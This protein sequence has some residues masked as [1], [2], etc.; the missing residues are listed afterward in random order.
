MK[1]PCIFVL[2]VRLKKKNNTKMSLKNL[3][4]TIS[5]IFSTIILSAQTIN[6]NVQAV[7]NDLEL[8][9][10]A[11]AEGD[12][13]LFEIEYA[14]NGI[15]YKTIA[16]LDATE[17]ANSLYSFYDE[18]KAETAGYYRIKVLNADGDFSYSQVYENDSPELTEDEE[19][20]ALDFEP[21]HFE[22]SY[23]DIQQENEME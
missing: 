2:S 6:L 17:G 21:I 9:W 8:S 23:Q 14:E 16:S 11:A 22:L 7:H 15:A 10:S 5:F 3:I 20:A 4:L 1:K 13:S 18:N 12:A 19:L